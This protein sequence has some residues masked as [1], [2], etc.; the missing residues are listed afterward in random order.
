MKVQNHK[1]VNS[2]LRIGIIIVRN[3]SIYVACYNIKI[4]ANGTVQLTFDR[5]LTIFTEDMGN[6]KF[7]INAYTETDILIIL[8]HV[9]YT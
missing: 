4:E 3:F 7:Y 8:P 5:A 2:N 6:R 1:V 9:Y